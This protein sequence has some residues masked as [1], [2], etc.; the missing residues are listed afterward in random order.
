MNFSTKLA[1]C[2]A[3]I[4]TQASGAA[5]KDDAQVIIIGGGMAG[6]SAAEKLR[7]AGIS[8]IILE[9][10]DEVGGRMKSSQLKD[11][12]VVELGA[13][14]IA[15]TDDIGSGYGENP[16]WTLK[17]EMGDLQGEPSDWDNVYTYDK[18]GEV[19]DDAVR[20]DD[21][22]EAIHCT[23]VEALR[24]NLLNTAEDNSDLALSTSLAKCGCCD[25]DWAITPEGTSLASA[26][27]VTYTVWEDEDWFVADPRGYKSVVKELGKEFVEDSARVIFNK[28]V[29][30]VDNTKDNQIKVTVRDVNTNEEISYYAAAV[31]TTMS[32]GVLARSIGR[33]NGEEDV[34]KFT[35]ELP[36]WKKDAINKVPLG[37][38]TKFFLQFS[39]PFWDIDAEFVMYGGPIREA[40]VVWHNLNRVPGYENKNILMVTYTGDY[41]IHT[42]RNNVTLSTEEAMADLRIMYPDATDPIDVLMPQWEQDEWTYGAYSVF[43]TGA[44]FW[45]SEIIAHPINNLYFAGEGTSGE[46]YGFVHGAYFSGIDSANQ[47]IDCLTN[48]N[49][50]GK[51]EYDE[52]AVIEAYIEEQE[53]LFDYLAKEIMT[54]EEYEETMSAKAAKIARNNKK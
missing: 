4:T 34:V 8:F 19:A 30:A 50:V 6:V 27:P 16:I 49:C 51:A 45:D 43:A 28:R 47:V 1:V 14:W 17:K 26:L 33:F 53:P 31:I 52:T 22:D 12:T 48:S 10:R 42:A 29:V 41:S 46:F 37:H 35:P 39:E 25:Y 5:I 44:F 15:G 9:G 3:L 18:D 13:N 40:N 38:Y 23:E 54:K 21:M 7:S 20:W 11:G 36:D 32:N 24:L 2:L